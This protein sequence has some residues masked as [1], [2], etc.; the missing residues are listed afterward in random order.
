MVDSVKDHLVPQIS[1]KTIAK[2]MFRALRKLFEDSNINRVVALRNHISNLKM[3]RS[4]SVTSYFMRISELRDQLS[5][6]GDPLDDRQLVM[7]SLNGLPS[8]RVLVGNPSFPSLN[9]YG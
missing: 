1:Q 8:F 9:V 7:N 6:I 5:T 4:K 2:K 3:S